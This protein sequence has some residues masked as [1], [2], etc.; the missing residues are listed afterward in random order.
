[1]NETKLIS[2]ELLNRIASALAQ[3][4]G[5]SYVVIQNMLNEIGNLPEGVAKPKEEVKPTK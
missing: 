5:L 1:M 3:M 2:V 4:T